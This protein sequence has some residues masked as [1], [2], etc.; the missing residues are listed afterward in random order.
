MTRAC[1]IS[2]PRLVLRGGADLVG[3]VAIV[4]FY[5]ALIQTQPLVT[6][7]ATL[8]SNRQRPEIPKVLVPAQVPGTENGPQTRMN[9]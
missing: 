7:T 8:T 4:R 2:S 6:H 3:F 1:S 5:V 9:A